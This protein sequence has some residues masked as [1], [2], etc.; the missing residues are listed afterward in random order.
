MSVVSRQL[1][2][3]WSYQG[4]QHLHLPPPA[5]PVLAVVTLAASTRASVK[6]VLGM[7]HSRH[8]NGVGE[9]RIIVMG[10]RK[11]ANS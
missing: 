8:V 11:A 10:H 3:R 2:A 6:M 4:G 1:A 7:A 5:R 9:L